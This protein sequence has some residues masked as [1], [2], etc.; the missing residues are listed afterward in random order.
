MKILD[1]L[2]TQKRYKMK[3]E[4][5]LILSLLIIGLNLNG[6]EF[7]YKKKLEKYVYKNSMGKLEKD[8]Q[9]DEVNIE[10]IGWRVRLDD[11]WGLMNKSGEM[12]KELKY[13]K[14]NKFNKDGYSI[15]KI[16]GKHGVIDNEGNYELEPIYQRID[17]YEEKGNLVQREDKWGEIIE[18]EFKGIEEEVSLFRNPDEAPIWK[19]CEIEININECSERGML[20]ALYGN[21]RYPSIAR[22]N[23]VQGEVLCKFIITENGKIGETELIK[24]I[25]AGCGEEAIR[26]IKK[27][28]NNW[29]PGKI[30]GKAVKTVKYLPVKYR[31]H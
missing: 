6:Q 30:D 11:K 21:I 19:G 24:N 26:I 16:N 2:K 22:E 12:M 13:E 15:V 10:K 8:K 31:L 23:S 28:L 18:G 5:I 1:I 29:I 27:H 20:E 14:I 17:Y 25:G 3:K 7:T 4:I 9:F